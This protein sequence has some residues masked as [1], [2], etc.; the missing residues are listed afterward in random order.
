MSAPT[1]NAPS[2]ARMGLGRLSGASSVECGDQ[3]AREVWFPVAVPIGNGGWFAA[4]ISRLLRPQAGADV[5]SMTWGS[6]PCSI[7][8]LR[9][10]DCSV[11]G[12]VMVSTPWSQRAAIRSVSRLSPNNS[13]RLNVP[14]GTLGR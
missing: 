10:L 8:T 2:V 4:R 9:A 1:K 6:L 12:I 3:P 14:W 7:S 13:W 11:T 5:A